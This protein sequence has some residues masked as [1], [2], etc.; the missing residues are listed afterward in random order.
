MSEFNHKV[1]V[2]E[3]N[4][5]IDKLLTELEADV[6]RAQIQTWIKDGLV[7]VNGDR[8]KPNYR[9][10][11]DDAIQW[12]KPEEEII[13]IEPEPIPLDII[14]EDD[15]LLVVN[16]EK[17]MVVHPAKAHQSGTLVNGLLH[18]T[19]Q[20]STINGEHRPGIVH[21]IDQD[22]SGLLVIAK[23]DTSYKAL[24]D[25]LQKRT[26]KRTYLALVHGAIPHEY[27]TIEAPIGRN[28]KDRKNMTVVTGGRDAVTYFEVIERINQ[29][30]TLIKCSLKTGRMHQIRVHLKYIGFPI[31][32]DLKYGQNKT[33]KDDG[34][35][36][37]A[38]EIGFIHPRTEKWMDF[39]VGP[40]Q[41]FENYLLKAK[42]SY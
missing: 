4:N 35:A 9:L 6:S 14:Y 24:A 38:H 3:E 2:N 10:E 25:Q 13:K 15:D 39:E 11:V 7:T 16:K 30:F 17:G 22:T 8:V 32:G 5:R 23:N 37:H 18:H 28:P 34:Q 40:P 1:N 26:L 21:R 31:V 36:L 29:K 33:F 27:G 42:E 41:S 19:N 12:Q 20:L